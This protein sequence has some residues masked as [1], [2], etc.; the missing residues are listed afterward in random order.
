MARQLEVDGLVVAATVTLVEAS[1]HDITRPREWSAAI[2]DVG[3]R[4]ARP[5]SRRRTS[6]EC[7]GA[8]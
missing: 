5:L 7:N 3:D 1:K 6:P 2:Q 8:W 4:N